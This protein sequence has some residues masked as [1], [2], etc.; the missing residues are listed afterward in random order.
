MPFLLLICF[1][2]KLIPITFFF[3]FLVNH[4]QILNLY[5]SAKDMDDEKMAGFVGIF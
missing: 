2:T 1:F 5:D 3:F 4:W